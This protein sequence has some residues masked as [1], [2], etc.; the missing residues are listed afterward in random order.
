MKRIVFVFVIF[1]FPH[2]GTAQLRSTTDEIFELSSIAFR[3]AGAEEY[4]RCPIQS[5]VNDIDL[6]FAPYADHEL[7]RYL[8]E[9][10]K[11]HLI[12]YDA[13]AT[14]AS[15]LVLHNG[16]I[17]MKPNVIVMHDRKIVIDPNFDM[18][19][20][21]DLDKRWTAD[22]YDRYVELLNDFY[23]DSKFGR[24]YSDHRKLYKKATKRADEV[25]SDFNPEWFA[26]FFGE[27]LGDVRIV[28]SL[29]NGN[30]NYA[31]S[32][33]DDND[34]FGIVIGC[35]ADAKG[36]PDYS[37][38]TSHTIIHELSHG[39]TNQLIDDI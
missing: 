10:R 5:Y 39:F 15:H 27:E 16:V 33:S 19:R 26:S 9:I 31:F 4:M 23:N 25:L 12:G 17:D 13:V 8:R 24:F 34:D 20:I 7:I 21:G 1:C 14:A 18:S 29:C 22:A 3:L 6:Y 2:I 32:L 38:L 37:P 28:V 36:Q 11:K 30:C 35:R